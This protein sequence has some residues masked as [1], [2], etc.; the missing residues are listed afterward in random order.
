MFIS[1]IVLMSKQSAIFL[2]KVF[3]MERYSKNIGSIEFIH[4]SAGASRIQFAS[5]SIFLMLPLPKRGTQSF[6]MSSQTILERLCFTMPFIAANFS[7]AVGSFFSGSY[8]KEQKKE[9]ALRKNK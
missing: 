3:K 9:K 7:Q 6:V 4:P 5:S 2:M 8:L 1:L